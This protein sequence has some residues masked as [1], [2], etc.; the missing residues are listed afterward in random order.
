MWHSDVQ[1]NL[2]HRGKMHKDLMKLQC[3][4]SHVTETIGPGKK[5]VHSILRKYEEEL[6]LTLITCAREK[7]RFCVLL[8]L[9]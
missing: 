3:K 4:D 7:L 1:G 5:N 9:S 6:M 2:Q 8:R